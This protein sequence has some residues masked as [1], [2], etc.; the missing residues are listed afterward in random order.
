MP[1]LVY[2]ACSNGET[3]DASMLEALQTTWDLDDM[4]D[5]IELKQVHASWMLASQLNAEAES[6]Q[7][8]RFEEMRRGGRR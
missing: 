4:Y 2:L 3:I 1:W 8:R 5:L 7:R 6:E